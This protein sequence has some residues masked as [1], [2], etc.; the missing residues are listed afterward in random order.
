LTTDLLSA[1]VDR[2]L[3]RSIDPAALAGLS[4]DIEALPVVR[5][6]HGGSAATA[7]ARLRDLLQ[8]TAVL[9]EAQLTEGLRIA[10]EITSEELTAQDRLFER[11]RR[12]ARVELQLAFVILGGLLILAAI[13]WWVVRR[14]VLKPLDNLRVLF[15]TLAEGDF[16]AVSTND[17]EPVLV[18]LFE[19]YNDLVIRL[20]MLEAEHRSRAQSLEDEVRVATQTLLEQHRSLANA[21]RLAVVG[22]MAAGVAHELRNPLAGVS[23]SLENLRRDATDPDV[24][25]RLDAVRA[26]IARVTRL[27]GQ[28]LV[29]ARHEPE[30][31]RAIDVGGLVTDLLELLRYQVPPEIT[32]TAH[33]SQGLTWPLPRDRSRQVLLNLVMNAVQALEGREGTVMIEAHR[34]D[35]ALRIAVSDDGPG[36]PPDRLRSRPRAFVSHRGGGTGLGLVMVQRFVDELG[37]MLEFRNL[38][39]R[40]ARVTLILPTAH[41]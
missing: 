41:G 36:F 9:T 1:L 4:A 7:V 37:G 20:R 3:G 28:Y 25:E 12:D 16:A 22:E 33:V 40:G 8:P 14:R 23:L 24:V 30:P 21:E 11:A 27:L 13:G 17:V 6:E 19:H 39:P 2:H 18:P 26:E 10:R 5:D 38:E 35:G 31:L 15:A 29:S 34:D 32:L